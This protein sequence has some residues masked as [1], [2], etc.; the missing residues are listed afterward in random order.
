MYIYNIYLSYVSLV[1]RGDE[2]FHCLLVKV[3]YL[4]WVHVIKETF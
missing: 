1:Y 2:V 4:Q 3:I